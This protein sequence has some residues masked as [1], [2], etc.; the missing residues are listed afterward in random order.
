MNKFIIL[1]LASVTL[2][3]NSYAHSNSQSET[4]AQLTS[5][6]TDFLSNKVAD[7]FKNHDS[8]WA[9]DLIY[10]SSAGLRFNKAY[11]LDGIKEQASSKEKLTIQLLLMIVLKFK[12]SLEMPS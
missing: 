6:L 11:I 2:S 3:F 8:F 9:D 12:F 5:I 1:L 4:K 7:D 10:T